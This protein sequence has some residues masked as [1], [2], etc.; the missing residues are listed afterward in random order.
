MFLQLNFA[1]VSHKIKEN[2]EKSLELAQITYVQEIPGEDQDASNLT[3]KG[4][5][6][7]SKEGPSINLMYESKKTN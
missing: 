6:D 7:D 3:R 5:I 2:H 1:F 4:I